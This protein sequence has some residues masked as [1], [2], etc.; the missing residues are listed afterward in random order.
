MSR[1][2]WRA[3]GYATSSVLISLLSSQSYARDT[4]ESS[5]AAL[6]EI[7][8]TAQKREEALQSVPVAIT[9]VT[10]DVLQ[11]SGIQT[12]QDLAQ[13]APG[14]VFAN[15]LDISQIFLRG[16][17][18]Y[19]SAAGDENAVAMYV[20]GVYLSSME[21]GIFNLN[22]IERIE[23]L[24]GPQ[25]TLFGRN[26]AGGVIQVITRNPQQELS[27]KVEAIGGSYDRWGGS[28]YMT[29]GI[30]ENL[31]ADIAV[32]G[33]DQNGG[34]GRNLTTGTDAFYERDLNVR[35][36][37]LLDLDRTKITLT[38]DYNWW[39]GDFNSRSVPAPGTTPP[40]GSFY[41]GKYHTWSYFDTPPKN[42]QYGLALKIQHDFDWGS[43][44]SIS[45]AR[46]STGEKSLDQSGGAVPFVLIHPYEWTA[47]TGTQEFQLVSPESSKISWAVGAFYYYDHSI[48]DPVDLTVSR[49]AITTPVFIPELN[50]TLDAPALVFPLPQPAVIGFRNHQ[51]TDSYAGYGQA[52][53]EVLPKTRLTAGV[54]YTWDQRKFRGQ[55]LG[56]P[57][58]NDKATAD[59]ITYR[60]AV[61]HDLAEGILAYASYSRGFKS[62]VFNLGGP[63][64]PPVK[65][66][67]IDAIEGGVKTELFD[68][69]VRL[70]AA[71][72]YYDLK[73]IQQ[74][75]IVLGQNVL[76]NAAAATSYGG[77][78]EI[79]AAASQRL[80][81]RGSVAY[82][83]A[84]FDSFPGAP[85]YWPNPVPN[86]LGGPSGYIAYDGDA[87]GNTMPD[88]PEWTVIGGGSYELPTNFGNFR[89]TANASYVG[90]TY[91]IDNRFSTDG[92]TTVNATIDWMDPASKWNVQLT[93]RNLFDNRYL[94]SRGPGLAPFSVTDVYAEPRTWELRVGYSW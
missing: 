26:A 19:N 9:A 60:L 10:A 51:Y 54:R 79:E 62:G 37:W 32:I 21:S 73:D 68:R 4:T 80:T 56:F 47:K 29:G 6:E 70:N 84:E 72:F 74:R 39:K 28:L 48:Y 63:P 88:S 57:K 17:G 23:V 49:V 93:A 77:E 44:A 11:S 1:A 65:P 78:F 67:T 31:A 7:I 12:T 69:R 30:T 87:K 13:I 92:E 76:F 45:S 71:G 27:G 43:F 86:P 85:L 52:T 20:D 8:V 25:G 50:R 61:D 34:Y 90:R 64:A 58:V 5:G 14:L 40:D 2:A 53:M 38:G 55:L 41:D 33:H 81:L 46:K 15:T 91:N 3:F 22:N 82:L 89:L 75:S 59:E 83:H 35:S 24:R 18:T 66:S 16:V 94:A 36:K 42:E